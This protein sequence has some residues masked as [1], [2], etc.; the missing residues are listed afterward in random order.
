MSKLSFYDVDNDYISYLK[1]VEIEARGF[2]HVPDMEYDGRQKFL[3]GV[4]LEVNGFKYYVPVTSYKQK[5]SENILIVFEHHTYNKVKGSLRFNFMFPVSD[6]YI[7]E[8]IIRNEQNITRRMFLNDQ[9]QFCIDNEQLI[10]NQARR[11]YNIVTKGLN[12]GLLDN[13][14]MFKLLEDACL[15]Y[16][17]TEG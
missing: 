16:G 11:T 17:S 5:Q 8:R 6:K 12:E 10:L 1:T 14:C 15:K 7:T 9:L 13:A 3:C 2:T 4:V